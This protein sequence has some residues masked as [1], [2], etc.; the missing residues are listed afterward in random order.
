MHIKQN[1]F[2]LFL[3]LTLAFL[4][5]YGANAE[6]KTTMMTSPVVIVCE[7]GTV[8]S[9]IAAQLFDQAARER[10]LPIRAISRGVAPDAHIPTQIAAALAGDGFDVSGFNPQKLS[11]QDIS[12]A[13][14]VVAIGIDLSGFQGEAASPILQWDDISSANDDYE[15]SKASLLAHI[16]ALLDELQ[17]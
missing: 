7:D 8:D 9:V 6:D 17:G 12:G 2:V 16:H 4:M 1:H 15:A 3:G 13:S 10:G 5:S 11:S 14:R